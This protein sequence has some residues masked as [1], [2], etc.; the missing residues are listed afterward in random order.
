[1]P[2]GKDAATLK[3]ELDALLERELG[4]RTFQYTRSDGSA[5]T[6]SLA[7][8]LGRAP[9]LEMAYNPN[10]CAEIRWGAPD[11]TE[12]RATCKRRTPPGQLLQMR[13]HRGWFHERRRP[14]RG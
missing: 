9:D 3:K 12:E 11:G 7:D 1:M 5:F 6:L 2:A 14:P 4:G 13:L 8:I 10:D